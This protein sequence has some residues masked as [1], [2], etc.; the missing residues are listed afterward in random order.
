MQGV[1]PIFLRQRHE[2]F[3]EADDE[4]RGPCAV[5]LLC[6]FGHLHHRR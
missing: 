2:V 1:G 3:L 6:L 5:G 4:T